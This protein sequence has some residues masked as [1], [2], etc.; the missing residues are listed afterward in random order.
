MGSEVLVIWPHFL[1]ALTFFWKSTRLLFLKHARFINILQLL[2]LISLPG[3]LFHRLS[4]GCFHL[5]IQVSAQMSQ[6]AWKHFLPFIQSQSHFSSAPFQ[7]VILFNCMKSVCH[8]DE[9][10]LF[11]YLCKWKVILLHY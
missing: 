11:I 2:H 10:F 1:S 7:N 4:Q 6:G 5:A 3:T 8:C 9:N